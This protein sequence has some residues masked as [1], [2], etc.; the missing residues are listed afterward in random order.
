[1]RKTAIVPVFNEEASLRDIVTRTVRMVDEVVIVD[2]GSTDKSPLLAVELAR[3]Y[4][5]KVKA[6]LLKKNRGKG[7]AIKTGL[8]VAKGDIVT[9]QDADGEYP[10]E[11]LP[12]VLHPLESGIADVC[13][14]SRF[15]GSFTGM[16][17]SHY[18]AN[19]I[20]SLLATFMLRVK[21]TDVMTGAKAWLRDLCRGDDLKSSSF[22]IEVEL[23]VKLLKVSHNFMEVPFHYRR[24]RVGKAKIKPADFLRSI[25]ALFRFGLSSYG[26]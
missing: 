2:D 4:P 23:T 12:N 19:R 9:I 1:M 7:Y 18:I 11:Q 8:R 3:Q 25:I 6:I 22:A 16:S 20:L 26:R 17:V 10:P 14:G 24:R 21:V 13:F 15:L 5:G